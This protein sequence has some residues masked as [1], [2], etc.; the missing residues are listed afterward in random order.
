MPSSK[1]WSGVTESIFACVK[2]TSQKQHGT[3]YEPPNAD[4]GTA[5]TKT[6]VGTVKL[7]FVLANETLTYTIQS[8][9]IIV[10]ES[11]IWNGIDET[12][13]GCRT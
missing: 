7:S 12:I 3:V 9:P 6:P 11:Q 5:T 13:K 2:T 10:S 4:S 1:S 8:K